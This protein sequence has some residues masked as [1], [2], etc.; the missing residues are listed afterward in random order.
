MVK[1]NWT[2]PQISGL[3]LEKTYVTESYDTT[4]AK[5]FWKCDYCGRIFWGYEN[6]IEHEKNCDKQPT[7]PL[8]DG[9]ENEWIV[10]I[11]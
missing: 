4:E 5:A 6:A 2:K 11:S 7:H 10:P 1:K 9:N 8:P 3:G